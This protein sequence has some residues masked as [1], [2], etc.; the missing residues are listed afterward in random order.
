MVSFFQTY[1]FQER[2][3]RV[4]FT[5]SVNEP[6]HYQKLNRIT[7]FA[8]VTIFL[9]LRDEQHHMANRNASE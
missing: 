5:S 3:G 9:H 8:F 2:E 6:Q 4:H 7:F 1:F